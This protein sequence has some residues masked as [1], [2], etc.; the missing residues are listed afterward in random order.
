MRLAITVLGMKRGRWAGPGVMKKQADDLRCNAGDV[1]HAV[2]DKKQR[3][4]S[5]AAE[6]KLRVAVGH[7]LQ[8]TGYALAHRRSCDIFQVLT[9]ITRPREEAR[10]KMITTTKNDAAPRIG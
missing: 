8:Y 6:R 1:E 5:D 2:E 7:T 4:K 3:A 10:A 9:A